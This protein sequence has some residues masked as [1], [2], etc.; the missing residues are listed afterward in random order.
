M[1]KSMGRESQ[2]EINLSVSGFFQTNERSLN[3]VEFKCSALAIFLI[4]L[5]LTN[6]G[7]AQQNKD[8]TGLYSDSTEK[9][10]TMDFEFI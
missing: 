1:S 4:L 8:S 10:F 6:I 3:R 7:M 9:I 5:T 2:Q